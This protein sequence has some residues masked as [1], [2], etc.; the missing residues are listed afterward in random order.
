LTVPP[1]NPGYWEGYYFDSGANCHTRAF[2][3]YQDGTYTLYNANTAIDNGTYSLVQRQPAIFSTKFHVHSSTYNWDGLLIETQGQFS[4]T[5]GPSNW[6]QITYVHK[7]QG[8][9]SNP[10][11]P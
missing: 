6:P 9:V 4:M 5:N 10:F 3:F 7:P 8:Y 2:K 11:C 1:A